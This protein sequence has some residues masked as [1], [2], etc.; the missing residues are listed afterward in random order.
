MIKQT[1]WQDKV[2]S[3]NLSEDDKSELQWQIDRMDEEADY[4]DAAK[5]FDE[6]ESEQ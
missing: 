3:G 6:L 4:M 1:T 2:A 5:I